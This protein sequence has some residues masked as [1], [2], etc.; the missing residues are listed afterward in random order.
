MNLANLHTEL[1]SIDG[2]SN[3]PSTHRALLLNE[4]YTELCTRSTWTRK[5]VEFG[6]TVIAQAAY[7]PP[8]SFSAS[9]GERLLS[10]WV[11][12][13]PYRRVDPEQQLEIAQGDRAL[14]DYGI[15]W[16]SFTSAGVEQVS[17]YPAPTVAGQSIIGRVVVEPTALSSGTDIPTVPARFHRAIVDYAAARGFEL[18]NDADSQASYQ[19]AFDAAVADLTA[20][21][22][23]RESSTVTDLLPQEAAA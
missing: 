8:A 2:L 5:Q 14:R 1:H 9:V 7:T 17:I 13:L 20:L 22:L 12:S 18:Q 16:I 3:I 11:N 19:A 21:R 6:P 4:G 15:Y 23:T 10:V